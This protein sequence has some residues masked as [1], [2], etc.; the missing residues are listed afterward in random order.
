[1]RCRCGQLR[2]GWR[3]R[4]DRLG[5]GNQQRAVV[6]CPQLDQEAQGYGYG[7]AL[8]VH[9][10]V[11]EYFVVDGSE[12]SYFIAGSFVV[13]LEDGCNGLLTGNDGHS[14]QLQAEP[15]STQ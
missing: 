5:A 8:A 15:C 6:G 4:L 9:V 12:Q 7:L 3:G 14:M 1:M 13:V 11:H 10:G 2:R